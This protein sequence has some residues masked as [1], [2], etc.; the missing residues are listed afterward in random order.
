M[1]SASKQS[2]VSEAP[3]SQST[4][5]Q[6]LSVLE[7]DTKLQIAQAQIDKKKATFL[8]DYN[9]Y[10]TIFPLLNDLKKL[11]LTDKEQILVNLLKVQ[12]KFMVEFNQDKECLAAIAQI[13]QSILNLQSDLSQ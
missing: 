10:G 6:D 7:S 13:N 12:Q 5:A 9:K 4:E 11:K 2:L 8:R 3:G 1:D